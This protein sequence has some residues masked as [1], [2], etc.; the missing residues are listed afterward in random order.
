MDATVRMKPTAEDT[1]MRL[2][3]AR[4][5]IGDDLALIEP[6]LDRRLMTPRASAS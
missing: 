1:G 5:A 4:G 3:A 6:S 2:V